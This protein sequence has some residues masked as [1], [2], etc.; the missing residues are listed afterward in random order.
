MVLLAP[1]HRAVKTRLYQRCLPRKLKQSNVRRSKLPKEVGYVV[2]RRRE[3]LS[4]QKPGAKL[5]TWSSLRSL[6]TP[7]TSYFK[8]T[9]RVVLWA[10]HAHGSSPLP[11]ERLSFFSLTLQ[12]IP[13]TMFFWGLSVKPAEAQHPEFLATCTTRLDMD[14]DRKPPHLM[15]L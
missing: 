6:N 4:E 15:R 14:I 13:I 12:Y 1:P 10:C 3:G 5:T 8:T 9:G 2:M 7:S 11:G